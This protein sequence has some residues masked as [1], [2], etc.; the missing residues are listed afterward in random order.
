[1]KTAIVTGA[2]GFVGGWLCKNLAENGY[3]V[4][5]VVRD[6]NS[7]VSILQG[8]KNIQV[9]RCNIRSISRLPMLLSD[10]CNVF[11]HLAWEGTSGNS[12]GDYVIQLSNVESTCNCVKV[13]K[14]CGCT[15]FVNAGSLMEFEAMEYLKKDGV[16]PGLSYVYRTAKLA[17]DFMAKTV[18]ANENI[19]YMN[20]IISNTYG[21]G[22][23]SA[24]FV[25]SFLRLMLDGSRCD[26]TTGE[27]LYDF[28]YITDAVE[29]IRLVA[30]RGTPY[31]NYYIGNRQQK[32]LRK[33]VEQMRDIANPSAVLKFGT[34]PL[35]DFEIDYESLHPER[36]Y[37]ELNFV[38]K[39]SFEEGIKRTIAWLSK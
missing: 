4:C 15:R 37:D 3:K 6:E 5:A 26:L 9:V 30:E 17:A 32:P 31:T 16:K 25:N 39:V 33:Y 20:V 19:S 34:Y 21:E 27:Q 22:E 18:A 28:L 38:Q 13:A 36:I 8:I 14:E 1:M 24:R 11:F 12:R 2:N 7:N 29:A 23:I 35:D 10:K